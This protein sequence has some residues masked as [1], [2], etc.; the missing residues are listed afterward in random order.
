MP[1]GEGGCCFEVRQDVTVGHGRLLCVRAS[2]LPSVVVL[3]SERRVTRSCGL[4]GSGE[5]LPLRRRLVTGLSHA[6]VAATASIHRR[7]PR[8]GGTQ[9][10]HLRASAFIVDLRCRDIVT[11]RTDYVTAR[12]DYAT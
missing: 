1:F 10:T 9:A 5:E 2:S 4:R 8:D 3:T 11:A 6:S 12:A 7:E